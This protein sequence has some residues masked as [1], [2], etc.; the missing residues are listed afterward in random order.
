MNKNE[1]LFKDM[2]KYIIEK[3]K[4]KAIENPM[5][6]EEINEVVLYNSAYNQALQDLLTKL[7]PSDKK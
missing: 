4:K 3:L 2:E 5:L 1:I 7:T 6:D